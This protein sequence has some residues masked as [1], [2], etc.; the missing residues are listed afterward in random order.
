MKL[1]GQGEAV[2]RQV[3]KYTKQILM[4]FKNDIKLY[5]RQQKTKQ[6]LFNARGI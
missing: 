6:Q 3:W 4:K 5:F 2:L 1:L